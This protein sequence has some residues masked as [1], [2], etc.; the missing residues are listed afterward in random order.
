MIDIDLK[1]LFQRCLSRTYTHVQ[2]SADFALER[3]GTT[4][5][6]Y[7]QSSDGGTDWC[8]NLNF[9]ARAYKRPGDIKWYAH[10]GFLTVWQTVQDYITADI[11]DGSIAEII[12][13]GYSHGAALA[14]L[15]HEYAWY[16][17]PDL[18]ES[19]KG[20]GFGCPRVVWGI[21]PKQL[22]QRWNNFTVI[23][24]T[25]DIVTHLPPAVF[26][27]SHVGKLKEIG[28]PGKYSRIDAHRPESYL[29]E[30]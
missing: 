8:N 22:K 1:R 21:K 14:V 12:I 4:L 7:F 28:I 29:A 2:N 13:V 25:D 15:C 27:Y 20:Y 26:G 23:R 9:P 11:N 3:A 24:N 19:L 6:I 10:R 5:Y 18:R 17:R 16:C 30:L